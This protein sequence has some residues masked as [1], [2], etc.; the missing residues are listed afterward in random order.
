MGKFRQQ[1]YSV[2]IGSEAGTSVQVENSVAIGYLAGTS[3]R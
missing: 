2:A 3:T 1:E